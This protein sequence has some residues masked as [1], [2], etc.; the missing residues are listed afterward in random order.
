MSRASKSG[1]DTT[2]TSRSIET[3]RLEYCETQSRPAEPMARPGDRK[4]TPAIGNV[5]GGQSPCLRSG[6]VRPGVL[7][8]DGDSCRRSGRI[9]IVAGTPGGGESVRALCKLRSARKG[10][11]RTDGYLYRIPSNGKREPT[12]ARCGA[13]AQAPEALTSDCP[14]TRFPITRFTRRAA[15]SADRRAWPVAPECSSPERQP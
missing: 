8:Q 11:I 13:L 3:I 10:V 4:A 5:G 1:Y 14:I 15:P 2:R 7:R 12:E 9:T 6:T